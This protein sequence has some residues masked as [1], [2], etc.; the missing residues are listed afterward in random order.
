MT[1]VY[2]WKGAVIIPI[3]LSTTFQQQSPGVHRVFSAL[4]L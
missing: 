2:T 4:I 3:S 1:N